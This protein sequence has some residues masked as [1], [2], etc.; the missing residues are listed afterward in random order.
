MATPEPDLIGSAEAC[1]ILGI[2][3]SVLVR[4]IAAGKLKAV[5]KMPGERGPYVFDRAE[6][7]R[8]A[9]EQAKASA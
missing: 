8:H 1:D 4:R 7:E 9:A 2:D 3:R 6:V 5:T